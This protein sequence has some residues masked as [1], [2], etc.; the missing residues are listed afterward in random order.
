MERHRSKSKYVFGKLLLS[1]VVRIP[2]LKA[3]LTVT[4]VK[5]DVLG[6]PVCEIELNFA[7]RFIFAFLA[8]EGWGGGGGDTIGP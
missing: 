6:R 1:A 5:A 8:M 3:A 7:R 2:S 4:R